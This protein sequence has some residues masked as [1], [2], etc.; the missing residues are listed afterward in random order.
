MSHN[1]IFLE[2]VKYIIIWFIY[3]ST[4]SSFSTA[5]FA[6]AHILPSSPL[7]HLSTHSSFTYTPHSTHSKVTT[8]ALIA[9]S[10]LISF[11]LDPQEANVLWNPSG[12]R[13]SA[14]P[15]K[16][17]ASC[18]PSSYDAA[19]GDACSHRRSPICIWLWHTSEHHL[20]YHCSFTFSN[21][22]PIH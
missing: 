5:I 1:Y 12:L 17:P 16:V 22:V 10:T 3:F 18:P 19:P 14:Q 15:P 2:I 11:T 9:L 21:L 13:I 8:F 20:L 4:A 6:F 7:S